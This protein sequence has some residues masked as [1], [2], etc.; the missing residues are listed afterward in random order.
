ML[1]LLLLPMCHVSM[2]FPFNACSLF[3]TE[4]DPCVIV[5][6]TSLTQKKKKKAKYVFENKKTLDVKNTITL[7]PYKM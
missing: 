2:E 1:F 3:A 4:K 5:Q 7:S 6:N